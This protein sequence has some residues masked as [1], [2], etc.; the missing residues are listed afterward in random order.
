MHTIT[1]DLTRSIDLTVLNR[2]GYLKEWQTSRF[3]VTWETAKTSALVEIQM[4]K[5][6]AHMML[7]YEHGGEVQRYRLRMEFTTCHF[8]R[9][10]W[11]I[12]CPQCGSRVRILYIPWKY[13]GCRKCSGLWYASQ[14]NDMFGWLDRDKKADFLE[15]DIKRKWYA[16]K[17]TRQYRRILKLRN[18]P[19]PD[20]DNYPRTKNRIVNTVVFG[21]L[22]SDPSTADIIKKEWSKAASNP[23]HSKNGRNFF[24]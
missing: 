18:I 23:V 4:G 8:G 21:T 6:E 9:C 13:L 2:W 17:P 22:L 12:R 24:C 5:F 1:A 15:R 14:H 19:P 20:F 11:W 7:K 3:V 10:R 16:G